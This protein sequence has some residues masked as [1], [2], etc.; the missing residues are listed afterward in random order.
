MPDDLAGLAD[1][2]RAELARRRGACV[3]A[4]ELSG[5]E[6]VIARGVWASMMIS[7]L[8]DGELKRYTIAWA[9]WSRP[10]SVIVTEWRGSG[11]GAGIVWQSIG[12][13]YM[14]APLF[15][16]RIALVKRRARRA[17]P[18]ARTVQR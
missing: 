16:V 18:Q 4:L 5:G 2:V 8:G 17:L 15:Y 7:F 11:M 1:E 13:G 12:A 14:F 9:G 6:H 3:V 10:F